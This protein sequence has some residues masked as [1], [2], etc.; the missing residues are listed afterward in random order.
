MSSRGT[1]D[2]AY[3]CDP[4]GTTTA[5]TR[6]FLERDHF[7]WRSLH[8]AAGRKI[9]SVQHIQ[10]GDT[11]HVYFSEGGVDAYIASYLVEQ[12]EQLADQ[13]ALAVEAVL[14]GELFEKLEEAGYEKDPE[15]DCFTGF[16]VTRDQYPRMLD[17]A[18][19]WVARNAIVRVKR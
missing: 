9:P 1:A 17:Q 5:T 6:Q 12:P 8:N 7:L 3:R 19:H 4:E 18:P 2:W 14:A 11:I 13:N 16:R 10:V 15:L